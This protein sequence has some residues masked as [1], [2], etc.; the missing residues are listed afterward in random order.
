VTN[1]QSDNLSVL[2]NL[3]DGTFQTKVDYQTGI[4]P[5]SVFCADLDN[6]LNLDLAV[7]GWPY[8]GQ[9]NVSILKNK[10]DGTFLSPANY[11]A[12]YDSYSIFCADLDGDLNLDLAVTN[13]GGN[14]LSILKS[15]GDGTFQPEINYQAGIHPHSV[16]CADLDEDKD[17]DLATANEGGDN[18]SIHINLSNSRPYSYSLLS[19]PDSDSIPNP[20][21][22][23]WEDA[24]DP[25]P[26]DTVRYTLLVSKSPVFH[27]D[28]TIIHDSLLQSHFSDTLPIG[29]YHWKIKAKDGWGAMRWS[30]QVW[31]FYLLSP[32]S[33]FSLFS[34]QNL[35]SVSTPVSFDWEDATDPDPD[36]TVRYTLLFSQSS[37]FHPDSTFAFDSLF[38]SQFTD[39]LP[40]GSHYW[41]VKAKDI[42]GMVRWSNQTWNFYS[43]L[44]GD[45]NNDENIDLS[46][47]IYLTNFY[48]KG[49]DPPPDPVCRA[50]VNGD[51]VIDLSDVIYLTNYIL[52]G[53]PSPHDCDDFH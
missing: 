43:F 46:D 36:D 19:P 49:E 8:P 12:G 31:S 51:N 53:G 26:D 15:F 14:N 44:C 28:S 7:A 24:T 3:G 22:L 48:L 42:W 37:L 34:P 52:K 18:I 6:D 21:N 39:S 30:E 35:D 27:P 5:V 1:L 33:S 16:F 41:K 23:D 10:G 47:V 17:F 32:P 13:W 25:D 2:K 40:S 20:V 9:G 45:V 11:G 38:Q 29:L 50:N 4:A